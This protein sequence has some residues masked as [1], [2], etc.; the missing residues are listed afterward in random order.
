MEILLKIIN[1]NLVNIISDYR[2]D[3][4]N[5]FLNRYYSWEFNIGIDRKNYCNLKFK[6]DGLNDP[7]DQKRIFNNIIDYK[8]PEQ[9]IL[10]RIFEP[11]DN[12]RYTFNSF[13][14]KV[15]IWFKIKYKIIDKKVDILWK[16][17]YIMYCD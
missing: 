1:R 8:I 11:I 6:E 7:N 5:Q 3:N 12:V 14:L 17:K 4:W 2:S 15:P 10:T 9:S 13:G 16:S